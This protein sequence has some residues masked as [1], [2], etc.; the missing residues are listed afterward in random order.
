M[1]WFFVKISTVWAVIWF[2]PFHSTGLVYMWIVESI[3]NPTIESHTAW[4]SER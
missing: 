3:E 1:V 4:K 2:S